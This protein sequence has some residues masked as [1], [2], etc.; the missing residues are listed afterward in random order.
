MTTKTTKK[1][2]AKKKTTKAKTE[3]SLPDV[4]PSQL[5]VNC[6]FQPKEDIT[7]YELAV[8]QHYIYV[9]RRV[10]LADWRA[11]EA[12]VKGITRH[13]IPITPEAQKATANVSDVS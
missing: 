6:A 10:T 3:T 13:L 1:T 9:E 12:R 4:D 5:V 2:A 7:A 8:L 11:L